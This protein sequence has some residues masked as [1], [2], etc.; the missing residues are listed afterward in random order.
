MSPGAII[1]LLGLEVDPDSCSGW[2]CVSMYAMVQMIFDLGG[3]LASRTS[4]VAVAAE[5]MGVDPAI[6]AAHYWRDRGAYDAGGTNLEYWGGIAERA[7]VQISAETADQLSADD[8]RL[9]TQLRVSA[10]QIVTDL[11][12]TGI[13]MHVLSNAPADLAAA[14]DQSTWRQLFDHVFISGVI[15][16]IK[17][18][19]EIYAHVERELDARGEHLVFI[20]DRESNVMAAARRGWITHLWQSDEDTESWL[21]ARGLLPSSA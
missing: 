2:L 4:Q 16:A 14:V 17:P 7:G 13:T 6:V 3:V 8:A 11:R 21:R 18:Q 10:Q 15:G 5:T 19:E 9:W 20:D 1:T 12:A